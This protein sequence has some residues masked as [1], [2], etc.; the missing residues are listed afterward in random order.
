MSYGYNQP[1]SPN[2]AGANGYNNNYHDPSDRGPS[3]RN[4]FSQPTGNSYQQPADSFYMQQSSNA[5]RAPSP[6]YPA[7]SP[8]RHGSSA[9]L[10]PADT[11]P[12]TSYTPAYGNSPGM[13]S[14]PS[15]SSQHTDYA[16]EGKSYSS[17]THLA[18]KEWGPGDLVP[19]VPLLPHQQNS[20]YGYPPQSARSPAPFQNGYGQ[21]PYQQQPPP[22]ATGWNN[23]GTQ[24]WQQMR[25]NLLERRVVKQIPL[26]NGNLVMDVPVPKGVVPSQKGMGEEPEEMEKLRYTA[27]T[28]DPDEFMQRKFTL[29]Q[30][31]YGRKT[32]LFVSW[33]ALETVG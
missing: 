12:P 31:L 21:Q 20:L 2:R 8:P 17:T 18:Q 28:C 6:Q 19:P 30:F 10:H 1:Y 24:H 5:Q 15:F 26:H 11:Y 4:D 16:D 22:S 25:N 9:N 23:W 13:I 14:R 7:Y 3:P 27:A 29:R 32:E 33:I